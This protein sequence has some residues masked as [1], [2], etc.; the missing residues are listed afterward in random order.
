[1]LQSHT[2]QCLTTN[3]FRFGPV[4]QDSDVSQ[5]S[6]SCIAGQ[7][8]FCQLGKAK[9]NP[10]IFSWKQSLR[11]VY[12]GGGGIPNFF[13]F[14][15]IQLVISAGKRSALCKGTRLTHF[16]CGGKLSQS[17]VITMPFP[18]VQW[19]MRYAVTTLG[20][21]KEEISTFKTRRKTSGNIPS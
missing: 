14:N 7:R 4:W 15:L 6:A 10:F 12:W 1:M 8:V 13:F 11:N 2:K 21:S 19:S 16:Q 20:N 9:T 17:P 3:H 18:A 5:S